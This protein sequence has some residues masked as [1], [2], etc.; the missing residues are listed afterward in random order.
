MSSN[1]IK[2]PIFYKVNHRYRDEIIVP[3]AAIHNFI[4]FITTPLRDQNILTTDGIRCSVSKIYTQNLCALEEKVLSL[5]RISAWDFLK[6]WH[7][8]YPYNLYSLEFV[9]MKLDKYD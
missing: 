7:N 5:Y 1:E 2:E 4:N 3:I 8:V 6:R 9:V